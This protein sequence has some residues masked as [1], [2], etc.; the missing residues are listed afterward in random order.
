[1]QQCEDIQQEKGPISGYGAY[2]ATHFLASDSIIGYISKFMHLKRSYMTTNA[3]LVQTHYCEICEQLI[4]ALYRSI[5]KTG[6][7]VYEEL[8]ELYDNLYLHTAWEVLT[9]ALMYLT[10]NKK[11]LDITK[12]LT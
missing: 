4:I 5:V 7:I 8:C 11:F 12:V 3:H 10:I 1:M 2:F 9:Q 6:F